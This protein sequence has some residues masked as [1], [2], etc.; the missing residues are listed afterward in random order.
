MQIEDPAGNYDAETVT[1]AL[2]GRSGPRRISFRYDRLDKANNYLGPIVD[3]IGGSIDYNMLADIKRTGKFT[4]RDTAVINYISDRIRPWIRLAMPDGGYVE[5]PQGVFLLSTP[6]RTRAI[7][8]VI[9]RDIDAYDQLLILKETKSPGRYTV[10]SNAL[11]TTAIK[12]LSDADGLTSSII[13]STLRLPSAMEWDPGTSHL[14]ILND[15]LAAINYESAFFNELG[16]L[17]CRPYLSPAIRGAEYAY[18]TDSSSVIK[19]ALDQTI[20]LFSVPNQWVLVVS[21]ADQAPLVATYTNTNPA[22]VTSTVS[23]GRTI[24]D[25]RTESD[26]AD[27]VT[28]DAKVARLAFEASQIYESVEFGTFLMPIHSNADVYDLGFTD[29]GVGSKYSETGWSVDLKAGST[30]KHKV[31]R[32]V[33]V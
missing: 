10:A 7:D 2:T 12:A 20:D 21:E 33:N 30:M 1:K 5:W 18:L 29:L 22:S 11:Y 16:T 15:L 26:A 24:T 28:L 17:I 13:P 3:V 25:H 19:G 23:R 8:G 27:Q 4:V 31:R 14:Q 32:I 6:K 9:T